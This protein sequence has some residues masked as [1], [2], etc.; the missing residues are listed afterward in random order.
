M[1][2]PW[3]RSIQA[4]IVLIL[5]GLL[6][7][8][9]LLVNLEMAR[10]LSHS[11]LEESANHLQIQ[12]LLAA[13]SLQ[14]PLSE[15]GREL[16]DDDHHHDRKNSTPLL[17]NW[18]ARYASESGTGVLIVNGQ[19]QYLAGDKGKL[20][21]AEQAAAEQGQPL[22]RWTS[23]SVY[24][25][26]P[27]IRHERLL[28]VVRLSQ[29]RQGVRARSYRLSLR[30]AGASLLALGLALTAAIWLSRRLV[31][32][33][34]NLES[35]AT[36]AAQ[37]HW[38]DPVEVPGQ[39]EL[40]SLSRAFARML[41]ELRAMLDR[42]RLFISNASH[43]LR[44]PLTRIKLRSEALLNACR[45]DPP[46]AEKFAQELDREVDGLIELANSL[47]DLARLEE[48]AEN[49]LTS[50]TLAVVQA[51]LQQCEVSARD[52]GVT[53]QAQLPESL[54]PL[55]LAPLSLQ[56]LLENLLDNAVKYTPAGGTVRLLSERT[57]SGIRW[58]VED[59]GIG[60]EPHHRGR[61]FERFYR[62]DSARGKGGTGLG[63]ALV[64]AAVESAGG[65]IEVSSQPGQGSR[66]TVDLPGC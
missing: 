12:T 54:P 39:D 60:I 2:W 51:A 41:S 56:L 19:G 57:Q 26:A 10:F 28:G 5:G 21:P 38:D 15:Y 50:D 7:G 55:R 62:V 63:L 48:G 52:K 37:G 53:L 33:L 42:Q 27:V 3:Q 17:P 43:E 20:D 11:Q 35:S 22:H 45:E 29:G 49:G 13:R 40:A 58:V 16:D 36:K 30:L 23:E 47:L 59:T 4:R 9:L 65:T 8:V 18:A 44:T 14:D 31:A 1:I 25:I 24:A 32:P 6:S 61:I 64:K 46:Q 34:Q 66:F